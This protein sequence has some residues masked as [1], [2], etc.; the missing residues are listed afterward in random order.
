MLP[1]VPFRS[2]PPHSLLFWPRVLCLNTW[3]PFTLDP[4]PLV[5]STLY[6]LLSLLH[7][8]CCCFCTALSASQGS[9]DRGASDVPG[10]EINRV[11]QHA[12]AQ[13]VLERPEPTRSEAPNTRPAMNTLLV[14]TRTQE[15]RPKRESSS[16]A[17]TTHTPKLLYHCSPPTV[18]TLQNRA[19]DVSAFI[20]IIHLGY[21]SNAQV[22][23]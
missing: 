11:V 14:R 9:L 12:K 3:S 4:V 20:S 21:C 2:N 22:L 13:P 16:E 15:S 6:T 5:G 10:T 18:S 19:R 7:N 23:S 8:P 17:P 1:R